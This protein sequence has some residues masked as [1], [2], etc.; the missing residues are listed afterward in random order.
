ME[1]GQKAKRRLAAV[2]ALDVVGYSRMIAANDLKA[3][4]LF[5]SCFEELIAP[6]IASHGGRVV[7]TM[8]DGVLAEFTSVVEAVGSAESIQRSLAAKNEDVGMADRLKLRIG[9]NLGDVIVEGDDIHGDGVNIAA[10]V[11]AIAEPGTVYMTQD[12]YGQVQGRFSGAATF[13][14]EQRLKNI[15]R[16]VGVW[17]LDPV[18]GA[19][20]AYVRSGIGRPPATADRPSIAVLPFHN[21]SGDPDDVYFVEG[22]SEDILSALS[23]VGWLFVIARATS[24]GFTARDRDPRAVAAN[25]GVV[26]ILDGS[27]RRAGKRTRISV[28]LV[29]GASGLQLW[30]ARYDRQLAD[31][32]DVQDEISETIVGAIQPELARSE[33]E[34]ARRKRSESLRA[35]DLCQRATWHAWR[36]TRESLQEAV[37]LFAAARTEDPNF[38]QALAGEADALSS[39][40]IRGYSSDAEN[41]L[42]AAEVLARRAVALDPRDASAHYSLGYTLMFQRRHDEAEPELRHAIDINPNYAQ[43]CFTLGNALATSGRAEDGAGM[44][45]RAMRLSPRDPLIGQMMTRL[46]EA[47]FFAGRHDEALAWSRRALQ[48]PNIQPSRWVTLLAILGTLGRTDEA[49]PA[50]AALRALDARHTA[51]FVQRRYPV[52]HPPHMEMFIAGLKRAGLD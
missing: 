47:Y 27:V 35:W 6:T 46:A 33:Q 40:F 42:E 30:S 14:G 1:Q 38:V 43:A 12:V 25:L 20:T 19:D 18:P 44:I 16:P 52:V 32:F 21:R 9:M 13:L 10:R 36:R 45:R 34:R 39:M 50:L 49:Q 11:E 7:K 51:G 41:V 48:Q 4:Q 23:H 3:R 5:N 26:Y 15:D 37:R 29:D 17:R 24:F 28:E 22:I 2:M 8:G 31:I